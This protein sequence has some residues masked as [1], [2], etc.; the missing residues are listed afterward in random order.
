MRKKITVILVSLILGLSAC[1]KAPALKLYTLE[2]G[3]VPIVPKS[4]YRHKTIKV[5][6]PQSLKEPISEKMLFSYSSSDRGA[7]QNSEWTHT[8]S[9]LLQ[10]TLIDLLDRSRLFRAV[11]PDSSLLQENYRLESN[12]FAFEHRVRGESS[13]AIVSIYF[14]LIDVDSGKLLKSKRFSYQEATPSTDAKGYAKAVNAIMARLSR[15]LVE[16]ID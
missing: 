3:E 13:H 14:T 9:K 16:W 2:V 12:I 11:L 5:S 8:L 6:Y 10:G 7:Y 1:S 4:P 15:D